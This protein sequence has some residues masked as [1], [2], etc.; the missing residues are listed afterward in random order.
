MKTEELR[1]KLVELFIEYGVVPQGNDFQL[2][3]REK[4]NIAKEAWSWDDSFEDSV[5]V[6]VNRM[7]EGAK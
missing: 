2:W 7:L 5:R 4:H 1:E 3:T 6:S